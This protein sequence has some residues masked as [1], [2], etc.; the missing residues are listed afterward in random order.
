MKLPWGIIGMIVSVIGVGV[1][2]MEDRENEN[3]HTQELEELKR[4]VDVLEQKDQ[5]D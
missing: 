4:R 5:E 3:E 2:F 1:E